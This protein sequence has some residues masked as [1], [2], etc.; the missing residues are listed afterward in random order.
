MKLGVKDEMTQMMMKD[1]EMPWYN[2]NGYEWNNRCRVSSIEATKKTMVG[3]K[4]ED[5][6]VGRH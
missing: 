5:G 4:S 6:Q 2:M 3:Q 1:N